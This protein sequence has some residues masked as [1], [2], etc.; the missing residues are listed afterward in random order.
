MSIE[1]KI[2]HELVEIKNILASNQSD[3]CDTD[4]ACR[5]IGLSNYR[6]L[7][8]LYTREILP[9][10]NRAEGYKYKKSD[11]YKVAA[12]LDNKTIVLYPLVKR[13]K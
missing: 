1:E 7:G 5:I 2:A 6:Y 10:Y 13:S 9:R 4:E 8:Q 11:C 3:Y 12:A